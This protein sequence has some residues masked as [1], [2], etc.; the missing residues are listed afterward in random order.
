MLQ[1][2]KC[3]HVI[4]RPH[5]RNRWRGNLG[6]SRAYKPTTLATNRAATFQLK[7]DVALY[8]G[9]AGTENARSQRDPAVNVTILSG[10]IDNNDSQTPIITNV[11]AVTGNDTN[12]Y[13][14]VTGADGATLDGFTITAGYTNSYA[15]PNDNGGGMYNLSSSSILK[16]ATFNGNYSTY[17]G[18][19][20]YNDNSNPTLTDVTFNGNSTYYYDGAGM[21]NYSSNPTLKNVLF[22]ANSAGGDYGGGMYNSSSN[23]VLMK[24]TFSGNS[25]GLYG[26]GMYNYSSSPTLT[27][28]T[29]ISNSSGALGGGMANENGSNPTL[30]GATF[31]DNSAFDYGGG[32]YNT[33][34]SPTLTNVT[35][36]GNSAGYGGG[37]ANS[38]SSPTLTKVTFSGN[39]ADY[40]DSGGGI[41][42]DSSS[43]PTI[44]D[45]IFWG[46]A[47]SNGAQIYNND[48]ASSPSVSES[49]VQGGYAGTNIITADPLLGS[50]GNYGGFTQTIPLLRVHP[51]SIQ[52]IMPSA[53]PPT[54][55]AISGRRTGMGTGPRSVISARMN[56]APS[57]LRT[58]TCH[59]C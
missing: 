48:A 18:G 27:N 19:G 46:N 57:H 30:M 47:A 8:G 51:P 29:F 37:M 49:V 2:G 32:I 14:V 22:S 42:N 35:F 40:G 41:Y 17:S 6:G 58:Y 44:R 3:L 28:A 20:M 10:D 23:P 55:A 39:S 7:S 15:D 53:P 56:L 31:S 16:N 24:V 59:L 50:L 26:A 54:S 34:S 5:R 52:G 33:S 12:S 11:I 4:N 45:T 21:Y 1:L 9:F 13:H 38:S 43:S 36:N 25:A